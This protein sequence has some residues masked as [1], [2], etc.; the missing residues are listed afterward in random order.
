MLLFICS[1]IAACSDDPRENEFDRLKD[2]P[3]PLAVETSSIRYES[4]PVRPLPEVNQDSLQTPM[5]SLGRVLFHDKRLSGDNSISC[6]TCHNIETGGV[7]NLQTSL[8]IR[9]QKG[10]INAPTVFNS[11][12]NF[13]HFW[14]GR[15]RTLDEQARFPVE[16]SFEMGADWT[17]VVSK[18][19]QDSALSERFEAAF[20]SRDISQERIIYALGRYQESLVTPAPFDRYL[21]GDM[22]AISERAREGYKTFK[23]YG[24]SSCHQGVNVGGNL[25]QRFGA[26]QSLDIDEYLTSN[27]SPQLRRRSD[28][29]SLV[30]VP[31]LRNVELTA[32][33]FHAGKVKDLRT[34]VRI[35]GLAQIGM[36]IPDNDVDLIVEFL[37]SLTGDWQQH[38]ELVE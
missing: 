15:A 9:N 37:K 23:T 35:M 17:V 11:G 22:D 38:A 30:K 21:K 19:L 20:G 2:L 26:V 28:N 1:A 14:D 7:D 18:L 34:A 6:A 33:Y 29:V 27:A 8:G 36:Q 12:F 31:S 5:V 24:C 4:E 3:M 16:E 25:Y 10:P 13:R 32:P